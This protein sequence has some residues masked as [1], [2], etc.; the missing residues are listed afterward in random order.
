MASL[1]GGNNVLHMC[2][3]IFLHL[4][5]YWEDPVPSGKAGAVAI[6]EPAPVEPRSLVSIACYDALQ[7]VV[8]TGA[9]NDVE[10]NT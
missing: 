5:L 9:A 4:Q 10:D 1:R 7:L 2:R 8:S 3:C 6:I